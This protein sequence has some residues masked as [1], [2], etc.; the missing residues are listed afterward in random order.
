M[1]LLCDG[2]YTLAEI[3]ELM[4]PAAPDPARVL[5]LSRDGK[6]LA[7]EYGGELWCPKYQFAWRYSAAGHLSAAESYPRCGGH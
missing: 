1:Q 5:A 2:S 4:E 7:F 6:I 3:V